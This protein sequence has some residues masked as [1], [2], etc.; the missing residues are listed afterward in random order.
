MFSEYN[1]K[2]DSITIMRTFATVCNSSC[3]KVMFSQVPVCPRGGGVHPPGIQPLLSCRHPGADTSALAET[4]WADTPPRWGP[5]GQTP[6]IRRAL[7]RTARI[8]LECIL[9]LIF[10]ATRC[11]KNI[12]FGNKVSKSDVTS[13]FG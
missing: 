4:S 8:L 5:P 3:G 1:I 9:V 10:A 7:Q 6:P 12:D 11:K 13:S 2:L